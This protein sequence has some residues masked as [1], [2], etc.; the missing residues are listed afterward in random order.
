MSKLKFFT[1]Y[2]LRFKKSSKGRRKKYLIQGKS[3]IFYLLACWG[4]ISELTESKSHVIILF[5]YSEMGNKRIFNMDTLNYFM[6]NELN[7]LHLG[8]F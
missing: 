3:F 5:N 7:V 6:M 8:F 1:R 2:N 4:K